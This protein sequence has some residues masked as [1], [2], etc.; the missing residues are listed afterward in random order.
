MK[1][2][3][4]RFLKEVLQ[5]NKEEIELT[6]EAQK[7]FPELLDL[8]NYNN[9]DFIIDGEKLCN[10]LGVKDNFNT[11]LLGN[12]ENNKG[13]L[14]KYKQ[15]EGKDYIIRFKGNNRYSYNEL[16]EMSPQ[17][18]SSL[19]IKNKILLTLDC[20]KI[21]TQ[22]SN[23]NESTKVY[24]NLCKLDNKEIICFE[25]KRKEIKFI[26]KLEESLKPFN[27]TG[28]RQHIIKINYKQYRIDYYI[29]TLNIAIEYDENDHN[30][31]T[32][33]QHEGRQKEIENKLR[34]KFIRLSDKNSDEYNIG[35]VIKN[36]FN[37]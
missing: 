14:I 19:G 27:I 6:M 26:D 8:E 1:K 28:E 17:K 31:Y 24:K 33:E 3:T 18:R 2:F 35:L 15:I 11:W 29:P 23:T 9:K 36:I 5:F 37:I 32:Y 12:R 20:A 34:C 13:K 21:I 22:K 10:Q 7:E 30:S 16:L 25:P 4:K